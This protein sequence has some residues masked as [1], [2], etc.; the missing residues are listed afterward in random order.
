MQLSSSFERGF[1][2]QEEIATHA[3]KKACAVF[4]FVFFFLTLLFSH[5]DWVRVALR[6]YLVRFEPAASEV[7]GKCANHLATVA[8]Y[9]WQ[10]Q[11]NKLWSRTRKGIHICVNYCAIVNPVDSIAQLVKLNTWGWLYI[12][13][14]LPCNFCCDFLLLIKWCM[15]TNGQLDDWG[16]IYSEH[17]CI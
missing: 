16:Y 7:K 12:K 8:P 17:S 10:C 1:T 15:W 9:G 5:E 4:F 11:C 3:C 2:L 13:A 14:C 6:M